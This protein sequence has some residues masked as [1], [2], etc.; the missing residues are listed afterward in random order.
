MIKLDIKTVAQILS[1]EW[2][3]QD[4]RGT[5]LIEVVT[6][7]TDTRKS[8]AQALFFALKG[9]NFD[10]H[11]YLPQAVAQGAVALVVEKSN[12]DISVPQ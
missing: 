8:A 2:I 7:M 4:Q 11:D 12:P 10:A 5:N 6:V 3:N 1:A 9:A